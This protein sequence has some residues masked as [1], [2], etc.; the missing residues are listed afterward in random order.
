MPE[1]PDIELYLHA[2]RTRITGACLQKAIIRSP[3]LLRTFDPPLENVEGCNVDELRREGKRI[4][5]R[6]SGD[7]PLYLVFH[8]MI[9]G[10]FHMK[11]AGALPKGKHQLAAFQ[12]EEFTLMLTEMSQQKRATLHL[13]REDGLAAHRRDGIDVRNCTL[14]EFSQRLA[15]RN[16][17]IKRALT[18]P[19]LF[20]GIGNAYSDEILHAAQVSPLKWTSRLDEAERERIWGAARDV[21][22]TWQ[23]RLISQ[24][25]DKFPEKVTAFRPEMA[26]HGRFGQPCPVCQAP[27]QRIVYAANECNYCAICQTEGKVL[28]DRSMSRLLKGDWPR[29]LEG[30]EDAG[31]ENSA[32]D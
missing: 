9:A 23:Q 7:A 13:V 27:V 32:S 4:L 25:G 19:T 15:K 24:A 11:K 10:R 28:A 3:S 29:T 2:L 26:V 16:R 14:E 5:W 30:W 21:L 31:N 8:L 6:M 18:D 1:L 17:T 22:D 12:F 20:D